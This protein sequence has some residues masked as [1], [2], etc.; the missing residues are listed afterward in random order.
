[1]A[2]PFFS[3]SLVRRVIKSPSYSD[4][5]LMFPLPI[6]PEGSLAASVVTTVWLG[7]IVTVTFNLRLGWPLAGLVVPGYLV[8]LCLIKPWS[9]LVVV[10]EGIIAYILVWFFS[11]YLSRYFRWSNLFGRDRFFALILS[12]IGVRL[13]FDGFLLPYVGR[14]YARHWFPD[15]DFAGNLHSFGLVIVALIANQF[16]KPGLRNG[17]LPFA[18]V[19]GVTFILVRYP[20]MQ[21][22]NFSTASLEYMY[23]D[24]SSSIFASPKAYIVLVTTAYMASRLNLKYSWEFNGIVIPA[25]LALQWYDPLKIATSLLEAWVI[26]VVANGVLKLPLLRETSIEGGRKILLFFNISF[27]YK[28]L[29]GH[30]MAWTFPAVQVTD[31]YGFGYLLP[32][33]LATKMHDKK[34]PERLTR[35]TLQASFVGVVCATVL[36]FSLTGLPQEWFWSLSTNEAAAEAVVEDIQDDLV[37]QLRAEKVLLYQSKSSVA[38]T[39]PTQSELDAFQAGL[40]RIRRFI[41]D[42]DPAFVEDARRLVGYA[43]FD[44]HEMGDGVLYLREKAPQRGWGIYVIN[45]RVRR[46]LVVEVPA[47]VA[48]WGTMESA[49]YLYRLFQGRALAISTLRRPGGKV[50]AR[51]VLSTRRTCFDVFHRTLGRQDVLQVRAATHGVLRRLH[52]VFDS[53]RRVELLERPTSL[54]VQGGLPESLRLSTLKELCGAIDV[55]W[56]TPR[57]KNVQR[58]I[59]EDGF[60][61]LFLR[62][63]DRKALLARHFL[64]LDSLDSTALLEARSLRD[65]AGGEVFLNEWL[66][67]QRE[68]LAPRGSNRYQPP[69]PEILLY[70]DQE[71]IAPLIRLVI[72]NRTDRLRHDLIAKDLRATTAAARSLGYDLYQH[73][74][75]ESG[76]RFVVL[77]EAGSPGARHY[78]GNYVFRL[79]GYSPYIVE[80][81]HPEYERN[82]LEYGV[83]LFRKLDAAVLLVAG[84]HPKCNTD[85]SAD[86]VLSQNAHSVFNLVNQVALRETAERPFMAI[87]VR[88]FG[89]KPDQLLP[90]VDALV[91]F[92][93]GTA[94]EE[95]LSD[96]SFGFLRQLRADG[97]SVRFVDGS[98][99]TTGYEA[100]GSVQSRYFAQSTHKEFA[101]LWLSPYARLGLRRDLSGSLEDGQ[102]SALG[103]A[104]TQGYLHRVAVNAIP[105]GSW[106][107][108]PRSLLAVIRRYMRTRDIQTLRRFQK[109]WPEITTL[110]FVDQS[111]RRAFLIFYQDGLMLPVIARLA[112]SR[113]LLLDD[114]PPDDAMLKAPLSASDIRSFAESTAPLLLVE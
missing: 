56:R 4:G 97:M 32:S 21:L 46:G 5:N 36:G 80:I 42:P 86:V 17:L 90:S 72:R 38:D 74:D 41:R 94:G 44:L 63:D 103:I 10:V 106:R 16:W 102:L 93:D 18:T 40:R 100:L 108:L 11:E 105:K 31:C 51:S 50:S 70:L 78:W 14:H 3:Y 47:P 96:M 26:Y 43:N 13:V 79:G 2:L 7:V 61:E 77:S 34:I 1:M 71:V 39:F 59:T 69:E 112:W 27:S 109:E 95:N 8:P 73:L 64:K 98:A 29:L 23:E 91:A 101:A 58:E 67:S 57:F 60:V 68:T 20:L 19:I 87:Q 37:E 15:F 113:S 45:T 89:R 22:T 76:E 99:E 52:G 35:T 104:T 30:V 48:E 66:L 114:E 6:F 88:A 53:K 28:L 24:V 107:D 110:R 12:S 81:P 111:S 82:T 54:W 55:E 9:A 49:A 65:L 62:R 75:V 33:L 83:S 85:N 84:S 92:L 25:L